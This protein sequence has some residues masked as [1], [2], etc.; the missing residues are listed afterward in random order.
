[1]NYRLPTAHAHEAAQADSRFIRCEHDILLSDAQIREMNESI[2]KR[3]AEFRQRIRNLN[4]AANVTQ[5]GEE[6]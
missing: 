4:T 2:A 1:M 5:K 3:S 6:E